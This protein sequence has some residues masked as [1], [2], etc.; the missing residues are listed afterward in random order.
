MSTDIGTSATAAA[1]GARRTP[2]VPRWGMLAVVWV[3]L[4]AV[5]YWLPLLGGYTAL[6]GAC[7]SS[8]SL[9]WG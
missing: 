3:V 7:W 6:A 8:G 2:A 1:I 9:R 4:I 5:P